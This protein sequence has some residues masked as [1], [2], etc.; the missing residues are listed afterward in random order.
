MNSWE[1]AEKAIEAG[2]TRLLLWGPPG[3]G[4]SRWALQVLG[5]GR[6]HPPVRVYL[7]Q[8]LTAQ[9]LLGHW[10]PRGQE[11]R[12]HHGPVA[13]AWLHGTGLV[14]D[15][16]G[17]ASGPVLDLMLA[18]LDDQETARLVL[19]S[20]EEIRPSPGFVA[21]CTSNNPP[22]DL[23]PALQ[24]RFDVVLHV[25]SPHPALIARLDAALKGLGNVVRDSYKD[26]ER[27]ISPRRALVFARFVKAQVR[28]ETA[29]KLAFGERAEDVLSALKLAGVKL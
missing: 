19:P 3:V 26:P 21:I 15:E 1:L 11:F 23:D 16:I 29:A 8:D 6:Q 20:G 24:D 10:V 9:E 7:N 27:A 13:W 22:D 12:W 17:R 5:E 14:V 25:P 18:V 2:A 4:K 28:A